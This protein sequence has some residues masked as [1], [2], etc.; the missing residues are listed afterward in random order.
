MRSYEDEISHHDM[1]ASKSYIENLREHQETV[2]KR[3]RFT[4]KSDFLWVINFFNKGGSIKRT[5]N[6][7]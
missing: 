4:T 1:V 7:F 3:Q 6:F 2:K 5:F